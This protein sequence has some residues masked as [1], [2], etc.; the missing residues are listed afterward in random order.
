M[1]KRRFRKTQ[2][3]DRDNN[4]MFQKKTT[5]LGNAAGSEDSPAGGLGTEIA[6]L[7]AKI[8]L[9][10]DIPKLRGY[11]INPAKLEP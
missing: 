4:K 1:P 6:A 10:S 2:T 8:G 9:T 11:E 5:I 7:F 3:E